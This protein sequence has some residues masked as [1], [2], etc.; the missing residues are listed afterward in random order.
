ME[1]KRTGGLG[2][3]YDPLHDEKETGGDPKSGTRAERTTV[4]SVRLGRHGGWPRAGIM[5]GAPARVDCSQRAGWCAR[6]EG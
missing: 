3:S 4:F 5:R 1:G 6:V 2:V